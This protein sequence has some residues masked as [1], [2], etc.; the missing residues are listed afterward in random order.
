M[1]RA[2]CHGMTLS[3]VRVGYLCLVLASAC[4]MEVDGEDM[5]VGDDDDLGEIEASSG[6]AVGIAD[7]DATTFTSPLWGGASVI[8]LRVIVPYDVATRPTTDPRRKEFDDW[9]AAAPASATLNIGFH[10][11]NEPTRPGYGRAPDEAT[12]RAA[13]AA[14]L[15]QYAGSLHR[16]RLDPWNEPNFNPHNGSRPLL[17]GGKYY[18]DDPDGA[19]GSSSPTVANCGPRMAAYYYRW[20]EVDCP[21]CQLEAGDFAGTQSSVYIQRYKHHLGHHRPEV[22]AVHNY[23]DVIRYQVSNEHV[24]KELKTFLREL[25]CLPG[26]HCTAT[27][28]WTSGVLWVTATGA[29]Y[30]LA[31]SSHPG[32]NCPKGQFKVLGEASQCRA[33]AFIMRW[34]SIS[35][36]ITRAYFYTFMDG[37]S[38]SHSDDTGLVSRDGLRPRKA[39]SVIRQRATSCP[40]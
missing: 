32:L 1:E 38:P 13:F 25:Y 30:S 31:C 29:N 6:M 33:A 5:P 39:Y 28:R 3:R 34:A 35:P 10:R 21:S 20:A 40:L 19:C 2:R 15:S 16:M 24:P 37:S 23:A 12:Y 22:W 26:H 8:R 14:F 36:R 17:P 7:S 9:L 18:L 27:T 11:I 4:A